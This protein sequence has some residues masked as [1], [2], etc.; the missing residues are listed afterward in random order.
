MAKEM[1]LDMASID[2]Q[3]FY[4][5]HVCV[6]PANYIHHPN[7]RKYFINDLLAHQVSFAKCALPVGWASGA[8]HGL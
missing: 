7:A 8:S 6:T 2:F 4:F 3:T 1:G 5:S